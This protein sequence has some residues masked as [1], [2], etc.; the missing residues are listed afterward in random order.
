MRKIVYSLFVFAAGVFLVDQLSP[1]RP[2]DSFLPP[3]FEQQIVN[4]LTR[5]PFDANEVESS[6]LRVK[7]QGPFL[8]CKIIQRKLFIQASLETK[9]NARYWI[10]RNALEQLIRTKQLASLDCII[11]LLDSFNGIQNS[12]P[13]FTF[14][15]SEDAINV[16]LIPDCEALN[17]ID[18]RYLVESMQKGSKKYPWDHKKSLIFWRGTPTGLDESMHIAARSW[19]NPRHKLVQMSLDDPSWIA[20]EFA[21]TYRGSDY[22]KNKQGKLPVSSPAYW[23]GILPVSQPVH[24][25]DHLLYRYL[26]DIDGY[27]CCFSRTFW[28]MLSNSLLFKQESKNRQWFYH[29]LKPYVHFIPLHEDLSNLRQQYLWC[30]EHENECVEMSQKATQFA[31]D[32]LGY[33]KNLGYLLKALQVYGSLSK[34]EPVLTKKDERDWIYHVKWMW[35]KGKRYIKKLTNLPIA[36][37][38]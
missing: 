34:D 28:I 19:L 1:P 9:N 25:Q 12:I 10:I 35:Y 27:S 38:N 37:K 31:L 13:I 33:Q 8:R 6:W 18:R 21:Y 20:A 2:I 5:A 15:A 7:D 3:F 14:S 29:G 32:Y 30:L 4:D 22:T 26:I 23:E 16:A 17:P 11:T 36:A 24:P